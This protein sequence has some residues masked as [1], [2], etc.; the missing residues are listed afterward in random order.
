MI[1]SC[2]LYA[3]AG[4]PLKQSSFIACQMNLDGD[5]TGQTVDIKK[6]TLGNT[7]LKSN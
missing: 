2:G 5:R 6:Y 1:Q 4:F 3:L 7:L